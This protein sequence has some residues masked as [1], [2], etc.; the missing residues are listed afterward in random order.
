[1]QDSDFMQEDDFDNLFVP[2]ERL[3]L[4]QQEADR[5]WNAQ[6]LEEAYRR[7]RIERAEAWKAAATEYFTF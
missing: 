1:M 6:R 4:E 2:G 3:T 5:K 7:I